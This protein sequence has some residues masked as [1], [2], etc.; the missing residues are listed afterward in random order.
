VRWL[1]PNCSRLHKVARIHRAK[2]LDASI[3]LSAKRRQ[4]LFQGST[5]SAFG[6]Q[7]LELL[8]AELLAPGISE[9]PVQDAR[10]MPK[11]KARRRN[12]SWARPEV[13]FR[14]IN[15]EPFRFFTRLQQGMGYGL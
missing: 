12:T 15:H 5:R 13:L 4:Q 8:C 1:T 3:H 14:K 6:L 11:V 9:Q 10:E 2:L 7:V